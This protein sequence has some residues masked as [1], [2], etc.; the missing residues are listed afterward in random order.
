MRNPLM[1]RDDYNAEGLRTLSRE[2]KDQRQCRR[3][4]ALALV[5]DGVARHEIA[6]IIGCDRQAIRDWIIKFNTHGPEGLKDAPKTGRPGRLT[7]EQREQ[8]KQLVLSEPDLAQD[9]VVRW[10]LKDLNDWMER[11]WGMRFSDSRL[12]KL[13]RELGLRKLSARPRHH[14]QDPKDI[15]TFKKSFPR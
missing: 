1:P 13:L 11:E 10:R 7:P 5:Y 12:G 8:L 14:E 15:E 2:V 9:G 4:I 6:R 3:L